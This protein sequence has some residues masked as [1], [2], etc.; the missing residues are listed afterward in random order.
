M[1]Y[2][3]SIN[4]ETERLVLRKLRETDAEEVFKNWTSDDEVSKY[5]KDGES[6]SF[7]GT[8]KYK[9]KV[10]ILDI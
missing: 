1:K 7:D 4:L 8:K 3:G 9:T 10:Y 5:S 6:I 2:K